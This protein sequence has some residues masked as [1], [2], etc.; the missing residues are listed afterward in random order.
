MYTT[1]NILIEQGF[2]NLQ[3]K[4]LIKSKAYE[5]LSVSLEAEC[6]FP[7]HISP[8]NCHLIVLEGKINFV[9]ENKSNH[10][11]RFQIFAFPAKV[12]HHVRAI[13]DTKFL[14]IR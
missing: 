1:N 4:Q 12:R 7:E 3:I 11:T 6:L 8:K 5:V 9:I 13:T 10:L 2:K 14:L